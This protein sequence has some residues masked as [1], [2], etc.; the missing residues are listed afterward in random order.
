MPQIDK[1]LDALVKLG[2]SDLHINVGQPPRLRVN[3]ELKRLDYPELTAP[4]VDFLLREIMPQDKAEEFARTQDLDMAYANDGVGRF[5]LNALI[6]K[7]GPAAVFR[8]VPTKIPTADELG[9]P[10]A[11]RQLAISHKGLILVTGATGSG[12]STTL[13]ALVNLINHN[14]SCHILTIEDPIEFVH[15]SQK[16]LVRQREVGSHTQ[17]FARALRAALREDPD[18]ILVGELRDP[19]T[20]SLAV[21][22]AET[23]HLVLGTLHSN[24]ASSSIDRIIDSFPPDQ[25]EQIRVQLS[26]TLRAVITQQLLRRHDGRGRVAAYEILLGNDAIRNLIRENKTFQLPQVMQTQKQKGMVTMDAALMDLVRRD[27]VDGKEAAQH[28]HNR[29]AFER[30]LGITPGAA[31]APDGGR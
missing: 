10:A 9:L 8:V 19:E 18:V 25:Q 16:A 29:G 12:K 7:N 14:R 21:T 24:S 22:A 27:L 2:G 3:G 15:E 1:F 20:I 4:Q 30:E 5:R 26:E 6:E 31:A 17:S 23:G 11:I 28:A 13:A